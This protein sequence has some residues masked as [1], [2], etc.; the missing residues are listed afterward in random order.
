MLGYQYSFLWL[1][2][3]P[4]HA[5]K[6]FCLFIHQLMEIWVVPISGYCDK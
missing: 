4:L 2:I 5:H 3:I 1:D 6:A